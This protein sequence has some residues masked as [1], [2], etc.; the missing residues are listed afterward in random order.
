MITTIA[1]K[2]RAQIKLHGMKQTEV[3]KVLGVQPTNLTRTIN[4]PRITLADLNKLA[5][6]IGCNVADFFM[7]DYT[8]SQPPTLTCPYCG[9]PINVRLEG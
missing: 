6:V 2:I 4:N 8:P 3:A 7:D 1:D 5:E 9:K